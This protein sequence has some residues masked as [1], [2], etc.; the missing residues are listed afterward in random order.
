MKNKLTNGNIILLLMFVF[1]VFNFYNLL[2]TSLLAKVFI[3]LFDNFYIVIS[4]IYIISKMKL[5]KV[6]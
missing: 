6:S 5:K 2:G 1:Y 4:L 3:A